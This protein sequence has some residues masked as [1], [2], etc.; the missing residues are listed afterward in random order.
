MWTTFVD[1]SSFSLHI[2]GGQRRF[3]AWFYLLRWGYRSVASVHYYFSYSSVQATQPSS[4]SP[5]IVDHHFLTSTTFSQVAPIEGWQEILYCR[6]LVNLILVSFTELLMRILLSFGLGFRCF[7]MQFL[8]WNLANLLYE[9]LPITCLTFMAYN[10]CRSTLFYPLSVGGHS[11]K[12][13]IQ[14]YLA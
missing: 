11:W 14:R 12:M 5:C 1:G 9:L 6:V 10:R 13:L 4:S 7:G 8:Q 3:L 2:H